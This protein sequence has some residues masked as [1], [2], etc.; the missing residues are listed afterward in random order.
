MQRL[1][2]AAYLVDKS[3]A[4]NDFDTSGYLGMPFKSLPSD[5]QHGLK[6]AYRILDS[7]GALGAID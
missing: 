3:G 2:Q 1:A 5:Q 4:G 7:K 6:I